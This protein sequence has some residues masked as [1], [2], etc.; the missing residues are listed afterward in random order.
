MYKF[1]K[2]IVV[3][4]MFVTGIM[5]AE[6]VIPSSRDQIEDSV[7]TRC[8]TLG[9][10]QGYQKEHVYGYEF[11]DTYYA[12][13]M[14]SS[15]LMIAKGTQL[16]PIKGCLSHIEWQGYI[17]AWEGSREPLK[18]M[19]QS[20]SSESGVIDFSALAGHEGEMYDE[21]TCEELTELFSAIRDNKASYMG[22]C[23]NT[24]IRW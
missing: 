5:A 7:G 24:K 11:N 4:L 17:G 13:A 10:S 6:L 15:K 23:G 18:L 2:F 12:I 8:F 14:T 1:I 3:T 22:S 16:I 21:F 19:A 9:G 20:S